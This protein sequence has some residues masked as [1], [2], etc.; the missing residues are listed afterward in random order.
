VK[1]KKQKTKQTKAP[2]KSKQNVPSSNA[3]Q[4]QLELQHAILVQSLPHQ[5]QR[6]KKERKR[7]W[8]Q[9]FEC[10]SEASAHLLTTVSQILLE[11]L[12][13]ASLRN[14]LITHLVPQ[15]LFI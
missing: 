1:N 6:E 15:A 11:A 3:I 12:L 8:G 10:L 9:F 4:F 13:I 5:R 7:V 14:E 2:N